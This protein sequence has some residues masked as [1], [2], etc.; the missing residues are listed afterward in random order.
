M[1]LSGSH[2]TSITDYQRL[3]SV[4]DPLVASTVVPLKAIAS[5]RLS[6]FSLFLLTCPNVGYVIDQRLQASCTLFNLMTV[7]SLS[8]L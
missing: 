1:A 8:G 7:Y 4:H 2:L 5:R 6:S 3:P